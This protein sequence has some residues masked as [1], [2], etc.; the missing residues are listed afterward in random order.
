MMIVRKSKM[1][2]EELKVQLKSEFEMI[3]LEIKILG[4]EIERDGMKKI[5]YLSKKQYFQKVLSKSGTDK[6]AKPVTISLAPYFK[7]NSQLSL[8]TDEKWVFIT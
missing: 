1:E 7:L 6:S 4:M 2:I 5:I 8:R 3:D